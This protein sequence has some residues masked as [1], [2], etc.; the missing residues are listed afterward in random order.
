M[1]DTYIAH[2]TSAS[3][4][5]SRGNQY[6]VSLFGRSN[7][8]CKPP[9]KRNRTLLAS[10]RR[11]LCNLL[12]EERDWIIL[13]LARA[14]REAN[15]RIVTRV[16]LIVTIQKE[17]GVQ[18]SLQEIFGTTTMARE[19][20]FQSMLPWPKAT[21]R[22]VHDSSSSDGITRIVLQQRPSLVS[23]CHSFQH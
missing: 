22:T 3:K 11:H 23:R 9:R 15:D 19:S 4:R 18:S 1:D 13:Y 21:G 6:T 14:P 8:T 12:E 2:R 16:R 20:P 7:Y 10:T 5:A 17:H